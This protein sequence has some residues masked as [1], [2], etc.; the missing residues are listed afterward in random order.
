MQSVSTEWK[1]N[2]TQH[3]VSEAFTEV[4]LIIGDPAA[5]GDA[6]T[7]VNG[8]ESFSHAA[9][10]TSEIAKYPTKFATL[11]KNI[12]ALDGSY[13]TLP[14]SDYSEQGYIG[15]VVCDGDGVFSTKP[16]VTVSF[17][18]TFT[19]AIPGVTITWGEAYG[20][21]AREFTVTAYN[22][23][24]VVATKTVTDNTNLIS[25]VEI[26]INNYDKI[27]V[28]ITKW[29]TPYRRSRI[30]ELAIGIIR[31]FEKSDLMG[32]SHTMTV[33]PL[34]SVCPKSEIKFSVKNLNGEYNP[35]NP[36]GV[37]KYMLTR[38]MLTA[39]Y[40]YKIDDSV[41]W[42]KAGTFFLSEWDMPQNGITATFTARDA[43]E[44]MMD[45]YTGTTRGTLY[46]IAT[47][48]FAQAGLFL[49]SDG[50]NRWVID[51]S[52]RSINAPNSVD[53]DDGTTIMEILQYC[54]NAACC[55]FYQDRD[56]LLHIEPLPN[57][58]TDYEINRFNS[59]ENSELTLSKQLKSINVNNGQYVLNVS[60]VGEEQ[61][62]NNPLIS[63]SQAPVVA[64]WVRDYLQNRQTVT[65][66]F[67]IDPR[68]DP[69]DRITNVNQFSTQSILVTDVEITFNGA[70][71]GSYGGRRSV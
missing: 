9:Y 49:M 56:G 36:Q 1:Q 26:D 51:S 45:V 55:V 43:L 32:Y 71:R 12:W 68:I 46:A 47:A 52:L 40:G 4:K 17:S 69:L 31:T 61:T 65:G 10:I 15:D 11:E 38:Q 66:N 22:G 27:V 5:I 58:T 20:E 53:L 57:G 28:T 7:S 6:S 14:D 70:F 34:S 44:Y 50:S 35:D 33:D 60:S 59:Y 41:E 19:I 30:K 21:W 16:T 24:A 42:I 48:A 2:Q 64:A 3:F 23:S 37:E 13:E 8:E 62:I 25:Y 29:G 18:R 39:K 54:A 67:R 63:D